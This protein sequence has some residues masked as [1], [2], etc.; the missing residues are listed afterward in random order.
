M[1]TG[2]DGQPLLLSLEEYKAR[3][4]S[5][6]VE[7]IPAL[8]DFRTTWVDPEQRHE[9]MGRLPD[10]GRAPLIVRELTQMEDYDLYDVLADV[11]YGQAPKT[12]EDRAAAFEYKHQS[13]ISAMPHP[14]ANTVRAI[15]SQ[16]AKG[17]TDN[18]E[19]SQI[20]STPEVAAA[21]GLRAL[22]DYGE[23]R[24]VVDETKRRMFAA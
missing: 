1:T 15:A 5:K 21:G 23:P 22:R 12:R 20:F 8:D 14:T 2:D 4:A 19:N 18:L 3:L 24:T 7:D 13:W 17:G 9:M 10:G 16:F 11:G 6:L